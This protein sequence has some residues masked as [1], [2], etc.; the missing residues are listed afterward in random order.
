MYAHFA[1]T[2]LLA[3][4][5]FHEAMPNKLALGNLAL[6]PRGGLDNGIPGG[7]AIEATTPLTPN[8]IREMASALDANRPQWTAGIQ[9]LVAESSRPD[10]DPLKG[11]L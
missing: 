7:M 4:L 11:L 6:H 2:T 9:M 10:S 1:D 8:N 3:N 5:M